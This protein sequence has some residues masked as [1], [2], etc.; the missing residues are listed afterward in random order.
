M[1]RS[2][3]A[4]A[5]ALDWRRQN[6]RLIYRSLGAAFAHVATVADRHNLSIIDAMAIAH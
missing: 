2:S 6:D 4:L 1:S 5:V 3:S